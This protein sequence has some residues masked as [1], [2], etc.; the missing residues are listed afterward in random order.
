[1]AGVGGQSVMT[2]RTLL[3]AATLA[4]GLA[5]AT[6]ASATVVT[7]DDLPE[8]GVVADGYGGVIW[9]GNWDNY[10]DPQFPYTPASGDTRVYS[11]RDLG[12]CDVD[13]TNFFFAAPVVFQGAY[14]AGPTGP[15][16][17]TFGL[18]Y[19]GVLVHTSA[20]L[21]ATATPTF[22]A[23]GY[24]GPVDEVRVNGPRDMFVMDDV[25]Y[26]AADVPE[27]AAW[28]LLIAGFGLAGASLRRRRHRAA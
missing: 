24:G 22:L 8:N 7:F 10:S 14:F 2:V 13:D 5:G 26:T 6:A 9:G 12:C 27:P 18:Y 11:D 19:G 3:A 21:D 4:L 20:S 28:A 23:S 25:T 17:I 1:M 16:A 15:G